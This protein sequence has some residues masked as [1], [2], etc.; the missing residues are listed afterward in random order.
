MRQFIIFIVFILFSFLSYSQEAEE[1]TESTIEKLERAGAIIEKA[2]EKIK[3]TKTEKEVPTTKKF[4]IPKEEEEE[5]VIKKRKPKPLVEG[6][7]PFGYDIFNL[8]PTTFEPLDMGPV[9]P[10]YPIG[11][12]DEIILYMWGEVKLYHTLTVD[13]EGKVFIPDVGRVIVNGMTLEGLMN[14]LK[15]VLS[16]Y[17]SGI[18]NKTVFIDVS[19]GKLKKIRVFVIGEVMAPGMY[20]ISSASTLLN[21]LYYAGGPTLKGSLRNIKLI[22]H[23]ETITEADIYRYLLYGEEIGP[24]L[25]NGDVIL[26]PPVGKRVALAGEIKRPGIYE[27]KEGE[28]L[29]KIIEIAGGLEPCAYTER[30]QITRIVEN[31]M[32][33]LVDANLREILEADSDLVIKDGDSISVPRIL[34]RIENYVDIYGNVLRPGKYEFKP[35]MTLNNLISDAGG[36]DKSA[37]KFEAEVSRRKLALD[38]STP[39][40]DRQDSIKVLSVKLDKEITENF[41]LKEN[42]IVF[43]RQDPNWIFQRN[44]TIDGEVLFPGTYSLVTSDDRL[45]SLIERAGGLKETAYP[46]GIVFNREGIGRIDVDLKSALKKKGSKEDIILEAGDHINIPKRPAT[47]SVKGAVRFPIFSETE[48]ELAKETNILYIPGKSVNYYIEKAGGFSEDADRKGVQLTL[49][50][51]RN[52]KPSK[53]LWSETKVPPGATIVVPALKEAKKGIDWGDVIKSAATVASSFVT[54]IVAIQTLRRY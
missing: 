10:D 50:N 28:N 13:R 11:P 47:V 39:I 36:L 9:D 19:L 37:Y 24:R 38:S 20:N 18:K 3:E 15:V 29:K 40:I 32:K 46:E 6:L 43:I 16:K 34:E 17:Y 42:D 49:P 25:N 52:I 44:V 41:E 35:G 4:A 2:K 26:V 54:T 45:S 27:L 31:K 5:A 53:F 7:K 12:G 48:I 30:V 22:R 23:N 21:A 51:G 1:T 33:E 14:R 8:M